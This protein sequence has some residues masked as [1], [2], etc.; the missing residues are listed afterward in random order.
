MEAA[1][2]AG[3][4]RQQKGESLPSCPFS[5]WVECFSINSGQ[6][7]PVETCCP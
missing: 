6:A 1:R 5:Y 4:T 7:V 2:R 3:L